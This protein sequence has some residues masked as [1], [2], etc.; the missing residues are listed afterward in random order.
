MRLHVE[1]LYTRD[2]AGRLLS[3]NDAGAAPAPRFLF[4]RTPNG[5]L[6]WFRHDVDAPTAEDLARLCDSQPMGLDVVSLE[7]FVERL[8]RVA[9]VQK[10]WTGPAYHFPRDLHSEDVGVVRVTASNATVLSPFLD[11]WHGDVTPGV[12]MVVA[13][14]DGKAVSVCASVRITSHAHEA[15]VDTNRDFRRR[16]YAAR[17]VT[18]W[19]KPFAKWTGSH[20]TARPGKTRLPVLLRRSS[21]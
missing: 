6:W 13:L 1:A 20:S 2:A 17:A 21:A 15:G 9:A 10:I 3:V 16:G 12:P 8:S 5:N 18:A 19:P 14:E 11:D 7:P 4:G